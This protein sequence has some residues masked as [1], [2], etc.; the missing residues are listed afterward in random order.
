MNELYQQVWAQMFATVWHS[1]RLDM[2]EEQ[3]SAHA[4]KWAE[5]AAAAAVQA[6]DFRKQDAAVYAKGQEP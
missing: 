1:S 4:K 3:L 6:W 2:E 5:S